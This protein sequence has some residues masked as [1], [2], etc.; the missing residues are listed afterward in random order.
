MSTAVHPASQSQSEGSGGATWRS[1]V[2]WFL[3]VITIIAVIY[4][5]YVGLFVAGTD[6]EQGEVQRLFYLHVPSF[7][8]A[9][10]AFVGTV[11]GGIAYLITRNNK[12][13]SLAVAGVEVGLA[14][15]IINLVTGSAWA[16]P[17]WNTWWNWDPRLVSDA[18]MILTYA[19]YLFLR[20]AIENPD[21]RRRFAAVYG[22]LAFTTVIATFMI[23]R[24]RPDT[25]HPVVFGPVLTD[26][27]MMATQGD[28]ELDAT[29][30][31][32]AAVGLN[33]AIWSMLVPLVLVW[34]R[35]RLENLMQRVHALKIRV[36]EK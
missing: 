1:R 16:R 3:T 5:L 31:V 12:W 32:T 14:L 27:S 19:A 22:I 8:G 2:L 20:N 33:S 9:T 13:D 11:V 23:I 35:I 30:G 29:P 18:I 15:A 25:I 28:F 7:S 17:I 4:G 34:H 10:I 24:I 26:A 6:I 36:L 21:Q